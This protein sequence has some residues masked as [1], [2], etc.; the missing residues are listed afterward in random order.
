M[1][2]TAHAANATGPA[3]AP[4][5]LDRARLEAATYPDVITV[6]LRFDD[7]DINWHVNNAAAVILL[8]EARARFHT[9]LSLPKLGEGYRSV[10]AALSVEYAAEITYPQDIEIS[11]GI[12]RI[13]TSSFTFAQLIRQ[14]GVTC[15]YS[16]CTAVVSKSQ[17]PA[18]LPE[19][20]RKT[21][22]ERAMLR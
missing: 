7:L 5:R 8:Q 13:G 14:N 11:T 19:S 6:P 20:W 2:A 1:T 18:P 15:I 22:E 17:G 12:L 9:N 3:P 4:G 16:T 21:H 10:I